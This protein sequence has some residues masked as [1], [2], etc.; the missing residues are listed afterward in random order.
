MTTKRLTVIGAVCTAAALALTG[1]SSETSAP[2]GASQ[3][4]TSEETSG[5]TDR[6]PITFAMG[7]NDT[8][9][10]SYT[11]LTLPTICSV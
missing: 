6:G 5:T 1:C 4:S 10:V 3:S 2:E 7:K 8:D 11:H 9:T